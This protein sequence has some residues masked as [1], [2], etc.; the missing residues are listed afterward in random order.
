M[1]ID[2][3]KAR[4]GTQNVALQAFDAADNPTGM[5]HAGT[6]QVDT[7]APGAA[8]VSV[9][10]GTA[11][12]NTSSHTLRWSNADDAGDVAPITGVRY[13]LCPKDT[14]CD[15]NPA[16]SGSTDQLS[17]DAPPGETDLTL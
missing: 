3:R 16:S 6:M 11:W 12:R 7:L 14:R 1:S 5:I 10:G 4:Q 13:R 8:A 17:I 15:A 9:D 2:V